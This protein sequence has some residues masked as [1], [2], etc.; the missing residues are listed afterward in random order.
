MAIS[1]KSSKKATRKNR[2]G[3]V[4][5]DLSILENLE[6]EFLNPVQQMSL[7]EQLPLQE[8]GSLEERIL[9][10]DIEFLEETPLSLED[11]ILSRMDNEAEESAPSPTAFNSN[12]ADDIPEAIRDKIAAYLEEVTEKDKKNRAPWLDIIE[13]AKN[14][15]WL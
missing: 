9:P 2:K 11:Q 13:K 10:E 7:E 5:A 14:F 3:T 12:F 1:N 4:I 8:T 15:T 6:P